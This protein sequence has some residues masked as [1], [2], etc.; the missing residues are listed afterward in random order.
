MKKNSNLQSI[1]LIN[2]K[3]MNNLQQKNKRWFK[4][5]KNKKFHGLTRKFSLETPSL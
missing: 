1:N 3:V 4:N 5:K 2:L